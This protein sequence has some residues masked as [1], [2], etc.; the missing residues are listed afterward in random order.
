MQIFDILK[1]SVKYPLIDIKSL[2]IIGVILLVGSLLDSL[3]VY[4]DNASIGVLGT[5]LSLIVSVF[6]LGYSLDI[7][8]FGIDLKDE[9]PMIDIKNNLKNG[10]KMIIVSIIYY[11]IPIIITVV[12]IFLTGGLALSKIGGL[13]ITANANMTE[14]ASSVFTPDFVAAI[15]IVAVIAIVLY[16]I[17]T[18]LALMGQAR[19]AKTGDIDDAISFAQSYSDLRQIGVGKTLAVLI[20]MYIVIAIII[21]VMVLISFIPIVGYLISTLLGLPFTLFLQYRAYGL[22]YSEIA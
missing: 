13:N 14:I 8:K 22:L 20:L 7:L 18:L 9:F 19:L 12:A 15:S 4:T 2:L 3:G 21:F 1:D 11:L 16:I 17:F 6:I 10:V 5:I